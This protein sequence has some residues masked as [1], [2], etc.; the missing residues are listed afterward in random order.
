MHYASKTIKDQII[1]QETK[2]RGAG[3]NLVGHGK[4]RIRKPSDQLLHSIQE[5]DKN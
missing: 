4:A 5:K 3:S 2:M 1:L